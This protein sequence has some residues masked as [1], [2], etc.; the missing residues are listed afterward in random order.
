MAVDGGSGAEAVIAEPPAVR[1]FVSVE[2]LDA[3]PSLADTA[4][5]SGEP[6]VALSLAVRAPHRE[7][8]LRAS[9]GASQ[10]GGPEVLDE[11]FVVNADGSHP[12]RWLDCADVLYSSRVRS[13]E[14]ASRWLFGIAAA[15]NECRIAA[16]PL[17]RGG[18]AVLDPTGKQVAL[19]PVA[20]PGREWL[21]PS[22]LLGWLTAGGTLDELT[23]A[24]LACS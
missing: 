2:L 1:C 10:P 16:A 17:A 11:H 14:A 12:P 22:C 13:T 18:W 23:S 21:L 4:A 24:Q 7:A 15:R 3:A 9:A 20:A 5:P 8:V 6:A 19:I